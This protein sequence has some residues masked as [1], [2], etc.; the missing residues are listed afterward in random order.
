[1]A[2]KYKIIQTLFSY[3]FIYRVGYMIRLFMVNLYWTPHFLH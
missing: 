3:N 2:H 1:M